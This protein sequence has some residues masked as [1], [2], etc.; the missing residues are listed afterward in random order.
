METKDKSSKPKAHRLGQVSR[1]IAIAV[2]ATAALY[3]VPAAILAFLVVI[4]EWGSFRL[5][6]TVEEFRTHEEFLL[7]LP[8]KVV[9]ETDDYV[10]FHA[11][12]PDKLGPNTANL[13]IWEE[14][15][16]RH[17]AKSATFSF[18]ESNDVETITIEF[19]RH[20]IFTGTHSS[21][22]TWVQAGHI[23]ASEG[24]E[25][26]VFERCDQTAAQW[27]RSGEPGDKAVYCRLNTHWF[28]YDMYL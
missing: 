6:D 20:G 11:D 28:A 23:T 18:N 25:T 10:V 19:R 24:L 8:Q 2:A 26:A 27:A 1:M 7:G 21:G 16:S 13:S 22:V 9:S 5:M 17:R 12:G 4:D 15:Q 3:I 14:V